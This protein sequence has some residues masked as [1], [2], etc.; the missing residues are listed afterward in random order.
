MI[1]EILYIDPSH[2]H[3][4]QGVAGYGTE[5]D[6][7]FVIAKRV[8]EILQ[9]SGLYKAVHLGGFGLTL[10]QAIAEANSLGATLIL[11]IHS[12]AGGSRGCTGLYKSAIGKEFIQ[13]VYNKVSALTPSSDRGVSQR[14]DLGILNQTKGVAGLIEMFFHDSPEDVAFFESHKEDFAVAIAQGICDYFKVALPSGGVTPVPAPIVKPVSGGNEFVKA[15][16]NECN[17]QGFKDVNR[18]PLG[19]DGIAGNHTLEA[20][21]KVI[22]KEGSAGN[23]VKILQGKIGVTADGKFGV[24]TKTK[25][26][27]FQKSARLSPDGIVGYNTWYALTR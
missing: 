17:A 18:S 22:L 20:L 15:L 2:Q 8:Y 5:A 27:E 9:G 12:D 25:V 4:N 16:Q 11:D 26:I 3:E 7:A 10:A 23:F 21:G 1:N 6:N 14:T 13:C 19:V 24:I